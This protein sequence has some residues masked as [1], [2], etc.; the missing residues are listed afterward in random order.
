LDSVAAGRAGRVILLRLSP[1][2]DL[3]EG[4]LEAC[5][6]MGLRCAV[7]L[8]GLG[9]LR[10]FSFVSAALDPSSPCGVSYSPPAVVEG[11]LELIS[12]SGV[13]GQGEGEG[14]EAHLHCCASR[15]KEVWAGHAVEGGNPALITVELIVQEVLD[16]GMRRVQDAQSPFRIF[17]PHRS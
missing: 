4:L 9:S 3:V 17:L 10:R 15:G 8:T 12:V 5:G 16:A 6:E 1:G 2:R 11:P 13:V 7:V 14:L